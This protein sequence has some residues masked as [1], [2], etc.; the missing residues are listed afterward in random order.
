VD[1]WCHGRGSTINISVA[2]LC[3]VG[4]N[5]FSLLLLQQSFFFS[6]DKGGPAGNRQE[7][8]VF[9]WNSKNQKK[10]KMIPIKMTSL[11]YK[12]CKTLLVELAC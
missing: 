1:A 11:F 6:F 2:P 4:Y 5:N 10:R 12:G 7:D 9:C 8:L 3:A